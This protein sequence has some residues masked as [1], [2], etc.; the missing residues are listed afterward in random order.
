MTVI[1]KSIALIGIC[2]SA[3][4]LVLATEIKNYLSVG[5]ASFFILNYAILLFCMEKRTQNCLFAAELFLSFNIIVGC[6]GIALF[7]LSLSHNRSLFLVFF[8]FTNLLTSVYAI[9]ASFIFDRTLKFMFLEETS[10]SSTSS[11]YSND[12]TTSETTLSTKE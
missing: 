7:A 8:A 4:F 10:S 5:V 9:F 12:T 11:L 6:A 3:A 1:A 2:V